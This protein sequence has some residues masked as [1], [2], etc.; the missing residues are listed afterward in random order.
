MPMATQLSMTHLTPTVAVQ[1]MSCTLATRR[2]HIGQRT[3]CSNCQ[4]NK[5]IPEATSTAQNGSHPAPRAE[6]P[7]EPQPGSSTKPPNE[8]EFSAAEMDPKSRAPKPM[9]ATP[10]AG[11]P[12]T[13]RSS[14]R[15]PGPTATAP[16]PGG[17]L[18]MATGDYPGVRRDATM[19]V[20]QG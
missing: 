20:N 17:R 10:T 18:R 15:F 1:Y 19:V 3:V 2:N 13:I 14:L 9:E 7:P 5:H 12:S 4:L 11:D 6:N 16:A 8:R